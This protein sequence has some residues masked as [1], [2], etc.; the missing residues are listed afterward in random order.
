MTDRP[1]LTK[2]L[3]ANTFREYYYL[4]EELV[5]FC[6]QE[7]LQTTGGKIELTERIAH[8]LETGERFYVKKETTRN[9]EVGFLTFDTYIEPN[10]VCSQTHREFFK[11]VIGR[12][13]SFNVEFQN[14]LKENSGKTYRDAVAAYHQIQEDK[15]SNRTV[16][17]K[18]F[19][20]NTYIRDFF[21][22]NPG[23]S[24]NHA[25][26]CWKYKRSIPGHNRYEKSDLAAINNT[27]YNIQ[28]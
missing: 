11:G 13:F 21:D 25:I 9:Y 10:F 6:R 24:L 4:K 28:Y 23:K 3:D 7:Y 12:K 26:A 22:D 27:G 8:Y 16:I 20:Y 5:E 1:L 17:S 18:Q 19:E 2:E 14:W 15:K